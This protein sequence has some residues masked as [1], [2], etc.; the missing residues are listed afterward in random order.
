M[1]FNETNKKNSL[2]QKIK[3]NWRNILMKAWETLKFL[4]NYEQ[5]LVKVHQV[6]K[7][8]TCINYLFNI[9]NL[10]KKLN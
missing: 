6:L 7:F 3:I 10:I 5:N 2:K 9:S 8:N 1:I 4:F